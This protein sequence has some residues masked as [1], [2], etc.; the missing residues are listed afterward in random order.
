MTTRHL[1]NPAPKKWRSLLHKY[2]WPALLL[3]LLPVIGNYC[4]YGLIVLLDTQGWA[5]TSWMDSQGRVRLFPW[6]TLIHTVLLAAVYPLARRRAESFVLL[7]WRFMLVWGCARLL[8]SAL[9]YFVLDERNVSA[10]VMLLVA[11]W[12]AREASRISLPHAYF[13][14]FIASGIIVPYPFDTEQF[15]LVYAVLPLPVTLLA[16]WLLANFGRFS[17]RVQIGVVVVV[18]V[19]ELYDYWGALLEVWEEPLVLAYVL[20]ANRV[21]QL[22]LIYVVRVGGRVDRLWQRYRGHK[23]FV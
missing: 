9:N 4:F 15:W 16:V 17:L 5:I 11:L 7:V 2:G 19:T 10:L 14:V 6:Q 8:A 13:L 1:E 22:P 18:A 23:R 12:F 21:L 20:T 3:L